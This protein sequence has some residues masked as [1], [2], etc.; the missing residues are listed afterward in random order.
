[1]GFHPYRDSIGVEVEGEKL[2]ITVGGAQS[3]NEG[4]HT[5]ERSATIRVEIEPASARSIIDELE[6]ALGRIE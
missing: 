1:M 2:F 3:W 6:D 5:N 4:R